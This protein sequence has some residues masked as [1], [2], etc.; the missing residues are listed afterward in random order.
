[1]FPGYL[2]IESAVAQ[3]APLPAGQ[4]WR[5]LT[6]FKALKE[7]H[8]F[9]MDAGSWSAVVLGQDS[10]TRW[11]LSAEETKKHRILLDSV[12]KALGES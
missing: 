9:S 2:D 3:G 5:L 10:G 7:L 11:N 4:A 6:A 8:D 12:E 1:M